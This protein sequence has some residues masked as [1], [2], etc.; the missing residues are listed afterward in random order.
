MSC[1]FPKIDPFYKDWWVYKVKRWYK[2]NSCWIKLA[3]IVLLII[4][5][6]F[7]VFQY[8]IIKYYKQESSLSENE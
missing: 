3:A 1:F 2:N 8:K 4:S 7:N 6:T 5:I